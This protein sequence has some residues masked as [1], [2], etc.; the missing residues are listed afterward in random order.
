MR[1]VT[2]ISVLG[3][4]LLVIPAC[5]SDS[6][7]G[8]TGGAAG[9]SGGAGGSAGSGTGGTGLVTTGGSG[10]GTTTG[11]T[12]GVGTGGA[13]T[14]GTG[15]GVNCPQTLMGATCQQISFQNP[16]EDA[17]VKGD[18]CDEFDT[19]MAD[20]GCSGFFACGN[21]CLMAG[22]TQES[23][24]QQ[25]SQCVTSQDSV[26][27]LQGLTNCVTTCVGGGTGGGSGTGGGAGA[28]GAAGGGN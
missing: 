8:N 3:A 14:G 9:S 26:N 1:L 2:L 7:G 4:A 22:G 18:C 15:G 12:G 13:S 27:K 5:S 20:Q 6:D 10:G 19:C 23:C 11:G 17:C 25:C 24:G 28:A 21:D 16:Q